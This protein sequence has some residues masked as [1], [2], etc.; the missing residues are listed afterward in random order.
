MNVNVSDIATTIT[1]LIGG[2]TIGQYSTAGR[3][4]NIEMRLVAAQRTRPEDLEL[5]RVHGC[6]NRLHGY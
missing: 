6:L 5:L 1:A 2:E 4:M 3:R